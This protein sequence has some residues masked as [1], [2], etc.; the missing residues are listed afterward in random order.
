MFIGLLLTHASLND[1]NTKF[2]IFNK[3]LTPFLTSY[4]CCIIL[5]CVNQL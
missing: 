2:F 3:N 5:F 4:D 1:L